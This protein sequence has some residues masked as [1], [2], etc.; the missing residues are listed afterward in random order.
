M[1]GKSIAFLFFIVLPNALFAQAFDAVWPMGTNEFSNTG[2]YGNAIVR[3]KDD[4]V[5][6]EKADLRMNFES[7]VSAI[8]DSL[9]N[10]LFYT[11]GCYIA[12]ASTDTMPNGEGLNPGAI[13]EWVCPE[14]GYISHRGAMILPMPGSNHLFYILL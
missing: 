4:S 6:V 9:G 8:S 2:G 7:T 11:N 5:F 13:H 12:T 14:N 10:L 1:N 3:F